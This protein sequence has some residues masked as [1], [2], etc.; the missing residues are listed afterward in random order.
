MN[1]EPSKRDDMKSQRGPRMRIVSVNDVYTLENLPRLRS[2]IDHYAT[3]DP[4]DRFITTL[5]G[6]F[7]S[8][9]I[10][11][12]LDAGRGMVDCMN[13]VGIDYVCLGNHE[14]DISTEEL[15]KRLAEFRGT[16]IDTNVRF[17]ENLPRHLV[18]AV[19]GEH[20]RTVK[21]GMIGVV[22]IDPAL[23]RRAPFNSPHATPANTTA[24]SESERLIREQG[25]ACVVP[26]T[27][28]GGDDDRALVRQQ[29][30]PRFPVILG[31]HE[32]VAYLEHIDDT[33]LVK[34]G[35]DATAALVIDLTWPAEAPLSGPDLP[36]VDVRREEVAGYPENAEVRRCVD[37]HMAKV[38]ELEAATLLKLAPGETLSS[39]G[40]RARQTSM[41]TI[42]C[43]RLRDALDA[44]GCLLNGGGIRGA[45]E[46]TE[47]LTYGDVKTEVP[48]DNEMTVVLLP[49]RVLREA[50]ASSRSMAPKERGSFLQVDDA[51]R[52]EEPGHRLVEVAGAPLDDDRLYRIATVR[53]FMLGMDRI[54]PLMRYAQENPSVVPAVGAGR[55]I[56]VALIDSFARSL[57][58]T[59][60]G[61]DA[62]DTN[63]DGHIS[64]EEV[65]AA[66]AR[67]SG[68]V[69]SLI[70]AGLVLK[71]LDQNN[72]RT[73]SREEAREAE[74]EETSQAAAR[75]K[76]HHDSSG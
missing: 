20:V 60:G 53:D 4:A 69:P 71:T 75:A 63:K 28:Q 73:V 3:H 12:S 37:H 49:G 61:F 48:F 16:C 51:M 55:E 76:L 50:I 24:I 18:L 5:A 13:R 31:G 7:V 33:W 64:E 9:S 11:S 36:H 30:A 58:S 32:H 70:T 41:G 43:S 67:T 19:S 23:Y 25:C 34:A 10:L 27:H 68:E 42:I 52:V 46:Y 72:D 57:W 62:V 29:R 15:Q 35:M 74:A 40:T 26:M 45:R 39:I 17:D 38:K 1:D 47:R 54:E 56:K 8:P 2:L 66:L 65:V 6:D 21:V 14:D 22:T 59:L 44:E